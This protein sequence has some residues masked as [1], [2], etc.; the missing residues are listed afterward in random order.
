M[1]VGA[2]GR[3]KNTFADTLTA[4]LLQVA[5]NATVELHHPT[6]VDITETIWPKALSMIAKPRYWSSGFL[7]GTA[8][9]CASKEDIFLH[10]WWA[11]L[12][13]SLPHLKDRSQRTMIAECASR[14]LWVYLFRCKESSNATSRRLEG[15]FRVWF[16]GSR[17]SLELPDTGTEFHALMLHYVLYR[18]FDLGSDLIL[19]LLRATALQSNTLTH[20]PEVINKPRMAAAIRAINLTWSS[21][22]TKESPPFPE[23][24]PLEPSVARLLATGNPD[25]TASAAPMEPPTSS[26]ESMLKKFEDLVGKIALL[27]D[28]QVG[29]VSVYDRTILP[30]GNNAHSASSVSNDYLSIDNE[31]EGLAWRH[32]PD[33]R[34]TVAYSQAHQPY[35][36]VLRSCINVWPHCLTNKVNR[37]MAFSILFRALLSP[38]WTLALSAENALRRFAA[39]PD[40]SMDL[41]S[42]VGRNLM[43]PELFR[44]S[45]SNSH[46]LLLRKTIHLFDL[47][48]MCF[49][50]WHDH[51]RSEQSTATSILNGEGNTAPIK[52]NQGSKGEPAD[53]GQ[54]K[55]MSRASIWATLDEVE[56]YSVILM[57]LPAVAL[58]RIA[59]RVSEHA[60]Q[61]EVLLT[62]DNRQATELDSTTLMSQAS[63]VWELLRA[64]VE[65]AIEGDLLAHLHNHLHTSEVPLSDVLQARESVNG[66]SWR[67]VQAC[68]FR[69]CGKLFPTI[70]A[71]VKSNL[72]TRFTMLESCIAAASLSSPSTSSSRLNSPSFDFVV[73]TWSSI[74]CCL[75]AVNTTPGTL[76]EGQTTHK[77]QISDPATETSLITGRELIK[78][79]L[80]HTHSTHPEVRE[81]ASYAVGGINCHLF[82]ITLK[83]LH[84]TMTD[85][86]ADDRK[87]A[88]AN[89]VSSGHLHHH[90]RD[91]SLRIRTEQGRKT[92]SMILSS[93]IPYI[94]ILDDPNRSEEV[95]LVLAW[96]KGLHVFLKGAAMKDDMGQNSIRL[97]F[98]TVVAHF[99][100][101]LLAEGSVMR[102]FSAET[103]NELFTL[104]L[105]WQ[106][107][108]PTGVNGKTKL[109]ELLTAAAFRQKD[110]QVRLRVVNDL[111][112]DIQELA[113]QSAK[114]LAALCSCLSILSS[115]QGSQVPNAPGT[116]LSVSLVLTWA[117]K[118]LLSP[119]PLAREPAQ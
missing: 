12:E 13:T 4:L 40:M 5:K 54:P 102:Y 99:V 69:Q 119:T 21:F 47:W 109:A 3:S 115:E 29:E 81:G 111:R 71:L 19:D 2:R 75:A 74:A 42:F 61:V 17:R 20:Q 80:A 83:E 7:L 110:E 95:Y 56:S 55:A 93:I 117:Q 37:N 65:R 78:E 9:L 53:T 43:R 30:A 97:A 51:L 94:Q 106:S 104:C 18:H 70:M 116:R 63:R 88:A 98:A 28:Q 35:I 26:I 67:S 59:A 92:T 36:D 32:H 58:R 46:D 48:A 52:P 25:G 90:R 64:P 76:S 84:H 6:W 8:I 66:V 91:A 100:D 34:A 22:Q 73:Q 114:T 10:D 11:F 57:A 24:L 103:I 41:L 72:A 96:I 82:F 107:Y 60:F 23:I 15:F 112:A 79:L 85:M 108:D 113:H 101:S 14:L 31:R 33:M 50:K 105:E 16:P 49:D 86:A 68:F 44:W 45:S 118:L 27:C 39:R 1:F 87:P 62:G 89:S 77:R 38:D